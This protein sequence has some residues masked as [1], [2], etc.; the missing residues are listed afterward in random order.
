MRAK[1][2]VL[3]KVEAEEMARE[4]NIRL[5]GLTGTH[6]GVIGALAAVGLHTGGNDGRFL[7]LPGLRELKGVYSVADLRT[8]A[9]IDH[10]CDENS[11]E[12]SATARVD[13]GDWVRPILRAG[14]ITLIVE[15]AE[16]DWHVISKDR[17]KKI[18]D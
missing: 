11:T 7:W 8:Y 2:V 4:Q 14:K 5:I 6:G 16:H 13:V 9:A 1:Q 12:L 3:K 10:V 17:I 15:E 18:S